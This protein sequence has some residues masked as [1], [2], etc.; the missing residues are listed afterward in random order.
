MKRC[1]ALLGLPKLGLNLCLGGFAVLLILLGASAFKASN[2]A[3][4]TA[5]TQFV[6]STS[7]IKLGEIAEDLQEQTE[8]I[9][10]RDM[11]YEELYR[12]HQDLL[13]SRD[14]NIALSEAIEAIQKLPDIEDI[15]KIQKEISNTEKLLIE[16]GSK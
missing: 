8:R 13:Y 10:R 12:K 16:E 1:D 15:K 14:G 7:A 6:T 2:F 9:E 5:N 3:F 11:A 4:K